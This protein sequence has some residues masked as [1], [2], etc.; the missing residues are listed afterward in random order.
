MYKLLLIILTPLA[1]FAHMNIA[2]SYP[3]IGAITKSIGAEHIDTIV[4]ANGNW[5]P[6][7]IVPRPSLISKVRNADALIMNGAQL[8]IG[9]LPPLIKRAAN[10]KTNV[11]AKTF[12]NLSNYVALINK[13]QSVNRS[14]GDL[15]PDGNPHFHLNPN[16]ILV[17]AK[18][19]KEF[20]SSIDIEHSDIYEKNYA[21]FSQEWNKK[22]T[23]WN[24]KMADKKGT[25]I[26]QFHNV[27]AYF[28]EAYGLV[29]I[30]AIEP[31]PG[32]PPSSKHTL[33]LIKLIEDE[34]P[35]AIFHD[36]YHST[37]T[38][39]FISSKADIPLIVMPHDVGALESVEDLTSLFDYLTSAIK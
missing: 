39:Q 16:N 23:L 33:N 25:K 36:V 21:D 12:L 26:I 8:E 7:F 29:N 3:Y 28:L 34:K 27:L 32:I 31:L 18:T 6:H 13:P 5:D 38:A 20:L 19:I 17:L 35:Y 1:L 9:W 22:L 10:P 4:L 24:E 30:G 2:V 11:N 15:H 14:G 37:K